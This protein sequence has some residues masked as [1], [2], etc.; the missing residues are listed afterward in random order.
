MLNAGKIVKLPVMRLGVPIAALFPAWYGYN[1]M[2]C[3][4]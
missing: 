2:L 1:Y 3:L 4:C